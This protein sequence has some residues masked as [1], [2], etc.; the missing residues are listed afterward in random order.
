MS[1][2]FDEA[3]HTY[4][5]DG[6]PVPNVTRVLDSELKTYNGVP[7]E[8]LERA[9]QQ[10][11]AIHRTIELHLAATLAHC[12]P[13][14]EPYILGWEAFISDTGFELEASERR[15]FHGAFNFAGTADLFG[16]MRLRKERAHV[17]IDLKRSFAGGRAIGL[18]T[19]AYAA[20]YNEGHRDLDKRVR[21][22]FALRFRPGMRPAY[23]LQEYSDPNDFGVFLSMLQVY[24][25]RLSDEEMAA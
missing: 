1:L 5:W 22:R 4:A 17:V 3:S 23:Q 19:A 18:Q 10:G 24:R 8:T 2:T 12:P 7:R 13:W 9:R 16:W 21:R 6:V 25:W 15:L 14:L 20:C 11:K